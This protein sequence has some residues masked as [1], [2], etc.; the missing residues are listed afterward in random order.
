MNEYAPKKKKSNVIPFISAQRR[1][2]EMLRK[3]AIK[4][5]IDRVPD[6]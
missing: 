5:I 2:S 3:K 4:R 6:K 1:K